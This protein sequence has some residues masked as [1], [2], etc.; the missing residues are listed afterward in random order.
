MKIKKNS[1]NGKDIISLNK[2]SSF[3]KTFNNNLNSIKYN[4]FNRVNNRNKISIILNFL[5][6]NEQLPLIKLSSIIS[7]I[8]INKYNLP[9]KTI[10]ALKQIKNNKKSIESKYS[11]ILSNFKN[12]IENNKIDREEYQYIIS[13]LL[14]NVNNNYI[15]FDEVNNNSDNSINDKNNKE[16]EI[17]NLAPR[18]RILNEL[19]ILCEILSKIKYLKNITHIK[20][21]LSNIDNIINEQNLKK[22]EYDKLYFVNIFQNITHIEI[23]KIEKSFFFY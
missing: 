5:D 8:L 19:K 7:K 6:I 3:I 20:F 14:K 1:D 12:I 16:K 10:A 13:F 4:F 23:D 15:I 2:K 11:K 21:N 18:K 9:F 22:C 17:N